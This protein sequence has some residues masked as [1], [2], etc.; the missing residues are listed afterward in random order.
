[1]SLDF[2][3]QTVLV[4]GAAHGFGRAIAGSFAMRGAEVF[5]CDVAEDELDET[6]GLLGER[7][8]GK[9]VNVTNPTAV[10]H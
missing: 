7:G 6:L 1:M 4:T 3:G 5:V 9:V 2:E 8:H 10:G